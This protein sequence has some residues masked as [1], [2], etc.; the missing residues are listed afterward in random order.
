MKNEEIRQLRKEKMQKHL[1]VCTCASCN[2][3]LQQSFYVSETRNLQWKV[4]QFDVTV[5]GIFHEL[6]SLKT[7]YGLIP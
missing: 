5:Y 1:E 2:N 7:K 4:I 3:A 6:L